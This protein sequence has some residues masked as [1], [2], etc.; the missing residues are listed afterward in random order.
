VAKTK[1]TKWPISERA[2]FLWFRLR[3]MSNAYFILD[4]IVLRRL[5]EC[6]EG[7][8]LNNF[9]N[10]EIRQCRAWVEAEVRY[11]IEHGYMKS[12]GESNNFFVL[13]DEDMMTAEEHDEEINDLMQEYEEFRDVIRYGG[14]QADKFHNFDGP[15][16]WD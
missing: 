10:A 15:V 5:D 7:L 6:D 9:T 14:E 3:G 2:K 1:K 13:T 8:S 12:V 4:E 11:L 16:D